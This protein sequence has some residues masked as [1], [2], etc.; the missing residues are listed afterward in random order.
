MELSKKSEMLGHYKFVG[1]RLQTDVALSLGLGLRGPHP[2]CF[3]DGCVEIVD[4]VNDDDSE[5]A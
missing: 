1:F 3:H 5:E 2:R 4:M